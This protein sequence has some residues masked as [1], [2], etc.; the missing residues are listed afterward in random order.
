MK[1]KAAN[2]ARAEQIRKR[3]GCGACTDVSRR[4]KTVRLIPHT[5]CEME[6]TRESTTRASTARMKSRSGGR[7]ARDCRFGITWSS[8]GTFCDKT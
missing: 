7:S 4:V 2:H 5:S 6:P 8:Q 1:S 3:A